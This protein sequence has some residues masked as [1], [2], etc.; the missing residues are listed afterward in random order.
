MDGVQS[1]E[2]EGGRGKRVRL[3]QIRICWTAMFSVC[4]DRAMGSREWHG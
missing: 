1:S 4:S 2:S 3:N